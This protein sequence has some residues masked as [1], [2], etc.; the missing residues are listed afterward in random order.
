MTGTYAQCDAAIDDAQTHCLAAG[1]WS[2][3]SLLV[4]NWI[5][6][7]TNSGARKRLRA[8][9]QAYAAHASAAPPG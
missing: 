7:S 9:A 4:W 2:I 1:W 5:A 8:Q 6:I 3:A